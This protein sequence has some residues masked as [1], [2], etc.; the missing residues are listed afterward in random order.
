M[1]VDSYGDPFKIYEQMLKTLF[2]K[3]TLYSLFHTHNYG[4][5]KL[6]GDAW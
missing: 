4:F 5:W 3:K 2:S 1:E 6:K